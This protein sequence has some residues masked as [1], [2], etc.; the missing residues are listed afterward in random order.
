M[1]ITLPSA[2]SQAASSYLSFSRATQAPRSQANRTV[3][4]AARAAPGSGLARPATSTPVAVI[5]TTIAATVTPSAGAIFVPH[6]RAPTDD[7]PLS[8][9]TMKL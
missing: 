2:S 7:P 8:V 1:E 5:T 6:P 9:F 4:A 3:A